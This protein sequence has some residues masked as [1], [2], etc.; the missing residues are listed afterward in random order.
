MKPA[1][2]S[3]KRQVGCKTPKMCGPGPFTWNP[4]VHPMIPIT[5]RTIPPF[6]VF[7][8]ERRQYIAAHKAYVRIARKLTA[9]LAAA[10]EATALVEEL[11]KRETAAM[12]K[13]LDL[14]SPSIGDLVRGKQREPKQQRKAEE[15]NRP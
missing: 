13:W 1:K 4:T 11:R 7:S 14:Y 5:C 3:T 2:K 9:A 10:K 8:R 6:S 15:K 12:A